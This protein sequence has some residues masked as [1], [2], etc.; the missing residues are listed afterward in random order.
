M[1][2][3]VDRLLLFERNCLAR[4]VGCR[5]QIGATPQSSFCFRCPN[6]F[7]DRF[8]IHQRLSSPVLADGAKRTV[9]NPIPFGGTGWV[10]GHD[11]RQSRFIRELLQFPFPQP[12]PAAVSAAAVGLDQQLGLLRVGRLAFLVPPSAND[13]DR[14]GRCFVRSSDAHESEVTCHII[15]SIGYRFAN[16]IRQKICGQHRQRL[17]PPG[18]ARIFEIANQ[19]FLL[20]I[21]ANGRLLGFEKRTP[22]ASHIAYLAVTVGVA[23]CPQPFAID[24][25]RVAQG[26][27]Q[28]ANRLVAGFEAFPPQGFRQLTRRFAR[29]FQTT[30]RVTDRRIL[31]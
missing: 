8:V 21:H 19:L 7:Q 10:M 15:D 31:E 20:R 25:Q 9:L 3:Q 12:T 13:V 14:K 1:W 23:A 29:P 22:L 18:A 4:F 16:R 26:C 5:I 11:N 27:Q 6:M 24:L 17:L 30:D 28:A 2:D